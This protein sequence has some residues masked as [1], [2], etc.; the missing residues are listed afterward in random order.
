MEI[1]NE[2]TILL[3][4]YFILLFTETDIEVKKL[5]GWGLTSLTFLNLFVNITV[6]FVDVLVSFFKNI[7][8][9]LKKC[10]QRL[11]NKRKKYSEMDRTLESKVPLNTD[12]GVIDF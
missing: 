4:S 7:K 5:Y 3:A 8:L 1:F 11:K 2:I 10:K 6:A 12:R 9:V